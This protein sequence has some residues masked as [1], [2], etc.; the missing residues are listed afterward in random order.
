MNRRET[1]DR[2][3]DARSRWAT[4]ATTMIVLL[5]A[6]SAVH[7]AVVEVKNG[8][9]F[10]QAIAQARPGAVIA[11]APGSYPGGMRFANLQGTAAKPIVI[12]A[13]DPKDRP[14]FSGGANGMQLSDPAHVTLRDLVFQGATH[15]GLNIDDA[16]TIDTPSHHVSIIN[17]L[18]K[19]VA[20][21]G[22]YDGI[23]LSGVDNVLVSGCAFENWGGQGIDMVGCHDGVIEDCTFN[24]GS[25]DANSNAVQCK[26]G[27]RGVTVRRCR[28]EHT[29]SR[30]INLGGSTG[31]EHFRPQPPAGY[32][33]KGIVVEHC[34]FIGTQVPVSFVGVDGATARFNTLYGPKKWAVRILQ[35]NTAP[36]FVPSRNGAFTDN[37]IVFR[38]NEMKVAVSVGGGTSP[39]TF[40]FA[41]NWWFCIDNPGASRPNLPN[42]EI[43]P[44]IGIDPQFIN[45]AMGDL[46]LKAGSP[47]VGVGAFAGR[48]AEST[49]R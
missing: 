8:D 12:C 26:G 47:A 24:S 1:S 33:A 41:R 22:N 36:G 7:A 37:I 25:D 18:I 42:K 16:A 44:V 30:A 9:Q 49:S 13:K 2:A 34:V 35:E 5:L 39:E 29:G 27:T 11:L 10:R 32:E 45:A 20:L 17:V 23:K 15:N 3:L 4:R 46:K 43:D 48:S 38:S 6:S 19:D 28:F 14:V 40:T 31:L 21:N